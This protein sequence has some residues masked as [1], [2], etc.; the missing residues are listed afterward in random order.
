MNEEK[1]KGELEKEQKATVK[2]YLTVQNEVN[3]LFSCK[4][5]LDNWASEKAYSLKNE[6]PTA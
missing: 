4:G 3:R 2:D 6:N 5:I 1:P